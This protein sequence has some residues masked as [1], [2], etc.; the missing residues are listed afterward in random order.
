M[1]L[2][3]RFHV[4]PRLFSSSSQLTT[5]CAKKKKKWRSEP[6]GVNVTISA[7]C[8]K[9]PLQFSLRHWKLRNLTLHLGILP[10]KSLK[11]F[12]ACTVLSHSSIMRPPHQPCV[13]ARLARWQLKHY[14]F[15]RSRSAVTVEWRDLNPD[16]HGSKMF[17]LRRGRK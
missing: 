5:K 1:N 7:S 3:N 17:F 12:S 2:T 4:V 10:Y 11:V 16:W 14:W 13:F 8:D 15:V 9:V 6:C